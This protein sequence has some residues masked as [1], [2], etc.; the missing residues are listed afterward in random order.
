MIFF[1]IYYST[2]YHKTLKILDYFKNEKL[3]LKHYD[4]FCMVLYMGENFMP[5]ANVHKWK[6]NAQDV[7]KKIGQHNLEE[8]KA[9]SQ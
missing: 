6:N 2:L 5:N 9:M 4:K 1:E 3:N 8:F 7:E